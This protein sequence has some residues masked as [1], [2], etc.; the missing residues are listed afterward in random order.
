M[1]LPDPDV[2]EEAAKV[3]W[4]TSRRDEGTI[5]ATGAKAVARALA[6]EGLLNDPRTHRSM[7]E[8]LVEAG[9]KIYDLKE[10]VDDLREQVGREIRTRDEWEANAEEAE[11][12]LQRVREAL[13]RA[14]CPGPPP[15]RRTTAP[16]YQAVADYIRAALEEDES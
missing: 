13:D 11:E 12:T 10:E 15:R 8:Q 1:T 9:H 14:C 6:V 4:E 7:T 5:S 2:I 16:A 3:I